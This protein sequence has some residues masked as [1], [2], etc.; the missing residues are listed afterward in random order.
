MPRSTQPRLA[1]LATHPIQYHSPWFRALASSTEVDPEVLYCHEARS[2]EQSDAGFG[3]EFNWDTSLL[4]GYR[5]RFLDNVAKRPTVAGFWGLDTPSI[6]K[7][8]KRENYDAVLINGWH[9]KSAWQAMRA[10]WKSKT[11]VMVR[12]DSHLHSAR[13]LTTRVAKK[14]IYN[15][16]IP[17]IDACLPVGTWSYEYFTHYGARDE[18]IFVVPHTIDDE[19]F[20]REAEQ[21]RLQR[22]ELRKEFGLATD[23][24]VFLFVGKFL[25]RKRPRV[26]ADAVA[27]A[28]KICPTVEGLM[29]GDGPLKASCEEFVNV[30][31]APVRFSG[32][33]NQSEITRAYVAADALILPSDA[34]ETWGLVVNEAMTC[35]LPCLVS[36]Q[37]G[38]GPDLIVNDETGNVFQSESTSYLVDL[39]L[40]YARNPNLL[41]NMGQQA[42][43]KIS[44]YSMDRVVSS[45]MTAIESVS[46]KC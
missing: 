8:I 9:Y 17:R 40:R 34:R 19:R 25:D 11:P 13:R 38:C 22:T 36:D 3:V 24:T 23:S 42:K 20:R 2:N 21:L 16:F 35:G 14:A 31:L 10:C 41:V 46:A 30:H 12:S 33:L 1:I 37:V 5:Y 27:Q 39:I 15:W 26:F 18:N 6:A 45:T 44:N 4:D 7:L 28:A 32:F 43:E 29:T